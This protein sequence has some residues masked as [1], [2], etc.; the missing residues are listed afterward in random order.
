MTCKA[1]FVTKNEKSGPFLKTKQQ[2]SIFIH[3]HF[4][5]ALN[6]S[7]AIPISRK[8]K[9]EIQDISIS[10]SDSEDL[11]EDA[12]LEDSMAARFVEL[13][14]D[15]L[16]ENATK[17]FEALAVKYLQQCLGAKFSPAPEEPLAL[18]NP[19][20]GILIRRKKHYQ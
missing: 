17:Q 4:Q 3:F 10:E 8:R 7:Q 6:V 16:A 11:S 5:M 12:N 2:N 19:P 15:W 20:G 1:F 13:S 18:P 9:A 14:T